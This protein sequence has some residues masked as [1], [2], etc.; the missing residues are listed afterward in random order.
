MKMTEKHIALLRSVQGYQAKYGHA[1]LWQVVGLDDRAHR[2]FE[3]LIRNGC[4]EEFK[5]TD[6]AG[7]KGMPLYR[8]GAD[9]VAWL[10]EDAYDTENRDLHIRIAEKLGGIDP[11]M[12]REAGKKYRTPLYN[13]IAADIEDG[14]VGRKT[15]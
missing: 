8:L 6:G 3:T 5:G 9:G 13:R 11:G 10:V 7:N 12:I 15:A 14:M 4:V 1:E 2:P